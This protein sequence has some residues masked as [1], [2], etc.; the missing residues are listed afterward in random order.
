MLR[1]EMSTAITKAKDSSKSKS[2]DE[3][4]IYNITDE[5]GTTGTKIF[6]GI[7]NEE[8]LQEWRTLEPRCKIID[9]MLRSDASI[10]AIYLAMTMPIE[11][12]DWKIH[13]DGTPTVQSKF[14]GDYL[15]KMLFKDMTITWQSF[16]RQ[17]LSCLPYSFSLFEEVFERD[18]KNQLIKIR[19]L[20]PRLQ[21]TVKRWLI[22]DKGGFAGVEQQAYFASA[23][24][25]MWKTTKIPVDKLVL[26]TY[27]QEGSNFEG[28]GGILRPAYKHW[29]IK[30]KLYLIQAIGL[31]RHALGIP[32]IFMPKG[33]NTEDKNYAKH[34]VKTWRAHEEAG[35][36]FPEGVKVDTIEGKFQNDALM[37]AIQH[38]DTEIGKAVLAQFMQLGSGQTGSWALSKDQS[39]MFLMGLN[40]VVKM[41][42]DTMNRYCIKPWIDMNFGKQETYH[43]LTCENITKTSND[44][45]LKALQTLM[46]MGLIEK[47][48]DLCEWARE[49]WSMPPKHEPT[50]E[51]LQQ[52]QQTQ[53]QQQEEQQVS[54]G[55][56]NAQ[57]QSADA[58]GMDQ[59]PAGSMSVGSGGDGGTEMSETN[60]TYWD[61]KPVESMKFA[62]G[63]ETNIARALLKDSLGKVFDDS[64]KQGYSQTMSHAQQRG[65]TDIQMQ[66]VLDFIVK[67]S[68][69]KI[70]GPMID[71]LSEKIKS[72]MDHLDSVAPL[73]RQPQ[74]NNLNRL[75]DLSMDTLNMA[76]DGLAIL[77]F[78]EIGEDDEEERKKKT[79]ETFLDTLDRDEG[80][81]V[82]AFNNAPTFR[83]PR[84]GKLKYAKGA[85]VEGKHVGGT[86]AHTLHGTGADVLGAM[87]GGLSL[88]AVGLHFLKGFASQSGNVLKKHFNELT[89]KAAQKMISGGGFIEKALLTA[90]GYSHEGTT[91]PVIGGTPEHPNMVNVGAS[92]GSRIGYSNADWK[93][94]DLLSGEAGKTKTIFNM[95][96]KKRLDAIY[97]VRIPGV[98]GMGEQFSSAGWTDHLS[99]DVCMPADVGG[100]IEN[101]AM[102][103][104]FRDLTLRHIL[105][106]NSDLFEINPEDIRGIN[107]DTPLHQYLRDPHIRGIEGAPM[108]YNELVRSKIKFKPQDIRDGELPRTLAEIGGQ[109]LGL[110][111]DEF[112]SRVNES[113]Y[114]NTN[115]IVG[116]KDSIGSVASI[117]GWKSIGDA[118]DTILMGVGLGTAAYLFSRVWRNMTNNSIAHVKQYSESLSSGEMTPQE[119]V[120]YNAML[121]QQKRAASPTGG[122][123]GRPRQ[124]PII[125]DHLKRKPG[126]PIPGDP[127]EEERKR[128]IDEIVKRWEQ[129]RGG[130][131]Q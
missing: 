98:R 104:E 48:E 16:V 109:H 51:E 29:F 118:S 131:S 82:S 55:G 11:S 15:E 8:Y 61:M 13:Y 89:Q 99:V 73:H 76:G 27:R 33:A 106:G 100:R 5:L 9:R 96:M 127:K 19:K 44:D 121:E 6:S 126:R 30:D 2:S 24:N 86:W 122:M 12:A 84:T 113:I 81:K 105:P 63:S 37:S 14:I 23:T 25:N 107:L 50:P 28:D 103:K 18:E 47:D 85:V 71:T 42:T 101:V 45:V 39:D 124:K 52:Q 129:E 70:K 72:V 93:I 80:K 35:M 56:S 54:P 120:K 58:G 77:A 17:S 78:K 40:S 57:D 115:K 49:K 67:P 75:C 59:G 20:A 117:K 128:N 64:V 91:I 34:V 22:D 83:D 31:E 119:A 66:G 36:L 116:T 46:Q 130:G 88:G 97:R 94:S 41:I 102:N 69:D 10:R 111:E 123:V 32:V 26:F 68:L 114:T 3:A 21:K 108:S 125:P 112:R 110:S 79:A 38:H 60:K 74:V 90:W 1:E 92:N 7:I 43:E 4:I 62:E 87:G 95:N 53:Q 65:I